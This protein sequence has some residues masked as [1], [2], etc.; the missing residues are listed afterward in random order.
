MLYMQHFVV[1]DVFN[2][3]L[4]DV[5]RIERLADRDV[6]VNVIVVAKYA[7]CSALRPCQGWFGNLAFEIATVELGEHP[8]KIVDLTP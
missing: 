8:V 2:K 5:H 4:G 6:V 3:P 7:A 1:E